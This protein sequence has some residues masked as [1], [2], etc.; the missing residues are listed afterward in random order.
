M[1]YLFYLFLLTSLLPCSFAKSSYCKKV[2]ADQSHSRKGFSYCV[3]YISN[4]ID[5][6][7]VIYFFHGIF[8]SERSWF[9]S[10]QFAKMREYML[11]TDIA[12]PPVVTLSFG[13][14]WLVNRYVAH[15]P[16]SGLYEQITEQVFPFIEGQVLQ[17]KNPTRLG[18]GMSMGGFNLAQIHL[19]SPR[20]FD[21]IALTCPAMSV[22]SPHSKRKEIRDF[23]S[24]NNAR[25]IYVRKALS[26]SK[27]YFSSP[28][29]WDNYSP[30]EYLKR[31]YIHPTNT[32]FYIS[33]VVKDEFGFLEGDKALANHL[34]Y[35]GHNVE[36]ELVK[37][38][39]C[40]IN[41]LSLANFI[42]RP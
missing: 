31:Y 38:N 21:K 29:D 3:D 7:K 30:I 32:R 20:L 40:D 34:Y 42:T 27:K 14:T 6:S 17:N 2:S 13:R 11:Q 26:L 28:T 37:G 9:K 24:R 41:P 23:I 19:Q 8:G 18:I 1:K 4:K 10:K 35:L 39:H 16:H 36:W 25:K 33:A 5:H 12:I 15:N 22:Q